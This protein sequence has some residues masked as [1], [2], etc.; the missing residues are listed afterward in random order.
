[1]VKKSDS[2]I[3]IVKKYLEKLE[4]N[5]IHISAAFLFGSAVQKEN[6]EINDIDLAVISCDFSGDRFDDRRRIVPMRREIDRRIEPIPYRPEDFNENDPL[7]C[8]IMR[9]AYKIT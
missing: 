3:K 7:V 8:E 9:T 6:R 2:I 1:M 5:R 4:E